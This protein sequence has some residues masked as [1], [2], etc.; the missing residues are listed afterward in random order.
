MYRSIGVNEEKGKEDKWNRERA[1]GFREE[2]FII[3]DAQSP[4]FKLIKRW[5][6]FY[7]AGM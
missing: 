4:R 1:E 7:P 6:L 2:E 3:C 5:G